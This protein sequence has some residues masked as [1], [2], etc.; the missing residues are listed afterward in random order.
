MNSIYLSSVANIVK[1]I[2][3]HERTFDHYGCLSQRK[4][5]DI[6]REEKF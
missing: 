1:I 2:I 3:Q 4:R 6:E 5:V